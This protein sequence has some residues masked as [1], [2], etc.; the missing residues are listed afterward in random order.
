[1]H[2]P[3]TRPVT[4]SEFLAWR[5]CPE[6]AW[7]DRH[8]P[9]AKQPPEALERLAFEDGQQVDALAQEYFRQ[10]GRDKQLFEC[11]GTFT[12]QRRY[13]VPQRWLVVSDVVFEPASG[14]PAT[15]IEVKA[16]TAKFSRKGDLKPE[17]RHLADL[18]Y[19]RFTI[20]RTGT[21]VERAGLLLLS[22]DYCLEDGGLDLDCFF[23]YHDVTS[24][25]EQLQADTDAQA[26]AATYYLQG[27]EP[28]PWDYTVCTNK[29][30]CRWMQRAI[31]LPEYSIFD[32]T[33]AWAKHLQGLLDEHI[34][35]INEVANADALPSKL[36]RQVKVAQLDVRHCDQDFV[37]DMLRDLP[38]PHYF[39]DYE[40]VSRAVP[41]V[42]G[43]WPYQRLAFQYSLHTRHKAG[44]QLHHSECL[45]EARTQGCV[46]LIEQLQRDIPSS[47]GTVIVWNKGFEMGVNRDMA[48]TWPAYAPYLESVNERVFDLMDVFKSE[49]VEDP[50]TKGSA[51]IKAV[52]PALIPDLQA[53]YSDLEI[54][55]GGRASYTWHQLTQGVFDE[56]DIPAVRSD[57]LKYCQLDT[58]AMVRLMDWAVSDTS[59]T[60]PAVKF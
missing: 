59:D 4:K 55:D 34:L 46:P 12:F 51:S 48:A 40:T 15:V 36:A 37:D 20:R 38:Y 25:V 42:V 57:L 53:G 50:A 31:K 7:L 1:M 44:G 54:S 45:L 26:A 28:S 24:A 10:P 18:A 30:N 58:L 35:D 17:A 14:D 43:M 60:H 41:D 52:L 5:V 39:L 33:G 9:T 13:E 8:E 29:G 6:E 32:L 27:P 16:S 49:A 21:S 23:S 3:T 19:Q 11:A 56:V 22:G 2:N 47:G